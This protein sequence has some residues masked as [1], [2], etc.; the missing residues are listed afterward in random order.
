MKQKFN[1]TPVWQLT[2]EF[3]VVKVGQFENDEIE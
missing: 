1:V 2:K 3:N